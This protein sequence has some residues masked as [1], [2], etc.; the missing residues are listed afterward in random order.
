MNDNLIRGT[1]NSDILL[2]TFGNDE[3]VGLGGNDTIIGTAG[4]DTLNGGSGIDTVDY[5]SFLDKITLLPQGV[6][7]NGS[8]RNGQLVEIER[9]V[10]PFGFKN[11][12]DAFTGRGGISLNV[13]LDAVSLVV[14]DVPGI[15]VQT[16]T[17]KNFINVKGTIESDIL[18]GDESDNLLIGVAGDDLIE[19]SGG[20]DTLRGGK[21]DDTLAGTDRIFRGAGEK[22]ILL[23]NGL[24]TDTFIL[25]DETGSFYQGGGDRDLATI[26]H[27]GFGELIQLGA[28]E[29]YT[30]E[31]DNNGF[32]VFLTTESQK[33][34]IANVRLDSSITNSFAAPQVLSLESGGQ[35]EILM[36]Q[37]PE[38]EFT[39]ASGEIVGEIFM[40]A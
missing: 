29:T 27:F 4:T 2:G 6:F 34:L 25:G 40:G 3:I 36:G 7:R 16:F 39:I 17:V 19:G 28:N 23:G 13:N 38:G 37:V 32:K 9:I 20:N 35:N 26:R 11:E 15:G 5:S 18:I 21:G 31:N 8:G 30:L 14:N 24:G 1:E 33:D 22:D 12:I 10:A